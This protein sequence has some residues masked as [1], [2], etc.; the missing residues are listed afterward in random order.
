MSESIVYLNGELTPISE[1]K[2]SILDRGFIF[3]DGIYD[4]VPMYHKK[5]FREDQHLA[6]LDRS[7]KF[8]GME[9]PHTT[10]E[11]KA[12]I[13]QVVEANNLDDQLIYIQVTRGAA[14]RKHAFPKEVKA[15]VLIMAN[16]S[17]AIRRNKRTWRGMRHNGRPSLV[18]LSDQIYVFIR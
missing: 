13:N 18:E 6:R 5:G 11:W 4:V 3:G 17:F 9:N 10:E 8:I 16:F 12:L 2:I 15:T 14:P 1:A 7:L